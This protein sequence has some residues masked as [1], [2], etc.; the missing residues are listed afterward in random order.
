MA[1]TTSDEAPLWSDMPLTLAATCG[2]NYT[3]SYNFQNNANNNLNYTIDVVV[4]NVI[5]D[6]VKINLKDGTGAILD[7]DTD[8]NVAYAFN[9]TGAGSWRFPTLNGTIELQFN[10]TCNVGAKNMTIKLND[11]IFGWQI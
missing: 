3:Y 9:E 10:Q 8:G 1:I 4:S 11:G 6:E 7:T 5:Q 2:S